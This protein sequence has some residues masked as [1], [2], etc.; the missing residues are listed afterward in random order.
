M[1]KQPAKL[2]PP[3]ESHSYLSSGASSCFHHPLSL[4]PSLS[5]LPIYL[6]ILH[7]IHRRKNS[8]HSRLFIVL[9]VS[10][11]TQCSCARLVCLHTR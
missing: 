3:S 11:P 4:P 9:L 2:N 6:R 5:S 1:G 7:P 10:I 8:G